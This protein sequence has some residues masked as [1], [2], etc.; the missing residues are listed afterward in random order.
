M[1]PCDAAQSTPNQ[2][3][4]SKIHPTTKDNL[5]PRL[6]PSTGIDGKDNFSMLSRDF[7]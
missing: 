4:F 3:G 1:F 7:Q 5:H 6:F 2:T